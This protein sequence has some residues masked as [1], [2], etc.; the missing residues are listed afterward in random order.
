MN[1]E[2]RNLGVRLDPALTERLK[3][4]EKRTGVNGATLGRNAIEAALNWFDR[5][6]TIMFPLHVVDDSRH[7]LNEDGGGFGTKARNAAAR[8]QFYSVPRNIIV[9]KKTDTQPPP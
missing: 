1:T 9:T 2:P 8:T 4:F 6:G 7:G 5:H 3:R